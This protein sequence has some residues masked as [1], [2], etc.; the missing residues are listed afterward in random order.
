[1]SL[2]YSL[3]GRQ[4]CSSL[5]WASGSDEGPSHEEVQFFWTVHH[6]NTLSVSTL[7]SARS[8]GASELSYNQALAHANLLVPS[9]LGGFCL[10]SNTGKVDPEKFKHNMKP[11]TEVYINRVNGY[12]C[13]EGTIKLYEGADS[14]AH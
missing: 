3:T 12:P 1:M 8:S 2:R 5:S 11:A 7:V 6:I 10:D 9:T 13:G 14:T 4:I